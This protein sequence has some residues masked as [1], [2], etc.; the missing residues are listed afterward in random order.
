MNHRYDLLKARRKQLGLTQR[1]V[2]RDTGLAKNTVA[3]SEER[4]G[5]PQASTLKKLC[6]RYGLDPSASM[7]FKL[8]SKDFASAVVNSGG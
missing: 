3:L 1:Q 2:G 4:D 7:N 6:I 5:N 8:R